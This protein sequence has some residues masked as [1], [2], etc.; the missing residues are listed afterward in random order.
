MLYSQ[1]M[2]RDTLRDEISMLRS[3]AVSIV[4]RDTEGTYKPEFVRAVLKKAHMKPT[5]RFLDSKTFLSELSKNSINPRP[6]L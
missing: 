2:E 6:D 3:L 1:Y 4:G 5:R